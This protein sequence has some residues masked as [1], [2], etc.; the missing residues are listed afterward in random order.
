MSIFAFPLSKQETQRLE[1]VSRTGPNT[2]VVRR[3]IAILASSRGVPV[4]QIA[5]VLGYNDVQVRRIIHMYQHHGVEWLCSEPKR[6]RP[7]IFSD[8][9]RKAVIEL[10]RQSPRELGHPFSR[11]SL[12][13]LQSALIDAKVVDYISRSVIRTILQEKKVATRVSVNLPLRRD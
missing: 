11:W 4:K 3:A 6:G 13:K 7:A 9:Q 12:S 8:E 10:S 2:V 5:S 1:Q